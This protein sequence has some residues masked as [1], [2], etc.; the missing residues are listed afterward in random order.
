MKA[1]KLT[2][3]EVTSSL[4]DMVFSDQAAIN[5]KKKFGIKPE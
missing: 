2:G 1:G 4:E 3:M 5:F